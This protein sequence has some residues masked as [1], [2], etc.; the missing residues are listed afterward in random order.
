MKWI[1]TKDKPMPLDEFVLVYDCSIEFFPRG[2]LP[3][4]NINIICRISENT[5]VSES[6][7]ECTF[8]GISHWMPLPIN[9][10]IKTGKHS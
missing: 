9:P 6:G 5:Y 2:R 3:D 1:R 7:D 4:L 8:E 10:N